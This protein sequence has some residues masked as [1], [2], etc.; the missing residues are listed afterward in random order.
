MNVKGFR[1][2]NRLIKITPSC[3]RKWFY[4]KNGL[5]IGNGTIFSSDCM[6]DNPN[7]IYIGEKSYIN[8]FCQFHTG[9]SEESIISIG[10]RTW[11]G[12]N[13]SFIGI[14]HKKGD[15]FK[16][17]G[18]NVYGSISIGD[19]SWIGANSIIRPNVKIG[20]GV[21]IGA[22]SVVIENCKDDYLYAGNPAKM[23]KK[24]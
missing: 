15:S 2:F 20:N 24:L 14:T 18:K 8:R 7:N 17:A 10:S 4:V 9:M 3:I 1:F 22:G 19:G 23:I 12:C 21:I 13:V 11:I 16:R 5:K 6:I